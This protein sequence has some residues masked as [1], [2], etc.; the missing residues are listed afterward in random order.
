[1]AMG[2]GRMS[3]SMT[4]LARKSQAYYASAAS[5]PVEFDEMDRE[6]A[7]E[8]DVQE[9]TGQKRKGFFMRKK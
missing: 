9:R 8:A 6:E 7:G 3:E 4:R 2:R 5:A 1:M